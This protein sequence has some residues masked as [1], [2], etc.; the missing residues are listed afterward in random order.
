LRTHR[1]LYWCTQQ[2]HIE[3]VELERGDVEAS[4]VESLPVLGKPSGEASR[5][6]AAA[7]TPDMVG[8]LDQ[9]VR[10]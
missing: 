10:T 1:L 2:Q 7:S 5:S 6:S 9:P 3:H 8:L 4:G